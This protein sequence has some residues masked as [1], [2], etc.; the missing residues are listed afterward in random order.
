MVSANNDSGANHVDDGCERHPRR[1][2]GLIGHEQAEARLLRAYWSGRMHHAWMIAGPKG[3]GKATLAYRFARFVLRYPNPAREGAMPQSLHVAQ[4]DPVFRRVAASAHCDLIAITRLHDPATGRLKSEI[5]AENARKAGE[6]FART[7]G[8]GGWRICIVDAA[9]DMNATAANAV[10]KSLEE[11][12]RRALFL[13]VSN[14]PGRLLAT[15][16]SRCVRLDLKPLPADQV[17]KVV[18][19]MARSA[20]ALN[21]KT[22]GLATELAQGAPGQVLRYLE[23]SG[24]SLF[25][26]FLDIING[27]PKLDIVRA[28]DFAEQLKPAKALEDYR[29]FGELLITWLGAR[30]AKAARGEDDWN[31]RIGPANMI[32]WVDAYSTIGHSIAKASALN[33]DRRQVVMQAF[34]LIDAAARAVC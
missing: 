25:N 26:R 34:R 31:R 32:G 28:L 24:F 5:N 14:A 4:D 29:L 18:H 11:P 8:G 12:P 6:F 23:T 16:R 15:I 22:L 21:N 7:S 3:V 20:A 17:A 9:D 27:T 19:R 13:L 30:I 33:L 1:Q 2:L 10:L